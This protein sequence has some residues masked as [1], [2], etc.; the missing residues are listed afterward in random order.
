MS[1]DDMLKMR[2]LMRQ[3]RD[4]PAILNI[5]VAPSDVTMTDDQGIVHKFKTD[6]KKQQV[7]FGTAK[8]D[9]TSKWDADTLGLEMAAGPMKVKETYQVTTQGH[10][11]VVTIQQAASGG[12]GAAPGAQATPVKFIY[13]RV[14]SGG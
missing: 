1:S 14:E 8:I 3:L 9:T 5:V 12:S 11:L 13:D 2:E 4:A 6:G 7:E 10:M